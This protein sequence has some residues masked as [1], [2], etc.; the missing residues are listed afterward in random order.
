MKLQANYSGLGHLWLPRTV[1]ASD[2][3]VSMPKVK[4]HHWTGVTL[5]LKNMF[6]IV[7]GAATAGPRISFTGQES[8]KAFSISAR[9]FDHISLLLT[10][11]S[12]WTATALST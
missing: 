10:V 6:A 12:R 11:S 2:F 4:T 1:L 7:P 3:I 9:R 8:T 5:S